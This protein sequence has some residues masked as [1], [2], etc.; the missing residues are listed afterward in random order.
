MAYF[1]AFRVN[2]HKMLWL[3]LITIPVLDQLFCCGSSPGRCML[4][5]NGVINTG[6][7]KSGHDRQAA[8]IPALQP[9]RGDDDPGPCLGRLRHPA[10][11][12]R[13]EKIDRSLLEAA[14]DLG[15]K[16]LATLPGMS[17]CR[18]SA[19]GIIATALMVFIPTVGD[20]VTP[21]LGGRFQR[22]HD[23]QH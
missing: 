5:F 8:G 17:P 10:D 1:L 11:L 22:Q 6:L 23:R 14:T 7:I 3:I 19:P 20:Y 15:D 4:G 18:L 16:P 12:C 2:R 9:N 13:L 21:T